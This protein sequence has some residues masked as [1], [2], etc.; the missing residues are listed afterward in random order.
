MNFDDL[1]LLNGFSKYMMECGLA[2]YYEARTYTDRNGHKRCHG[3]K[4]L[5]ETELDAYFAL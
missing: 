3:T 2:Q 1:N 5:K 4:F